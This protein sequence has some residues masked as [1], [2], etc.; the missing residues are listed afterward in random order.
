MVEAI[1]RPAGLQYAGLGGIDTVNL[2]LPTSAELGR[3]NGL[4]KTE[5]SKVCEE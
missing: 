2:V 5:K 4:E 1:W 3:K